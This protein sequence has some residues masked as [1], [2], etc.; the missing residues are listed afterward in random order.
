MPRAAYTHEQVAEV[1]HDGY[2]PEPNSGCWLWFKGWTEQ[3][4]SHRY[5]WLCAKGKVVRAHRYSWEL[6]NG[7]IPKGLLVCH[8]CDTPACVNPKHLFLG[9]H[10]DNMQDCS[11]KGRVRAPIGE[12][13][14]F[15]KLTEEQVRE[16][17]ATPG[18]WRRDGGVSN[19]KMAKKYG[20]GI[21]IIHNIRA[22]EKWKHL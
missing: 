10:K 13:S 17:R 11:K 3:T 16:I 4:P 21:T 7:P 1:F 12:A 20:V 22:G 14:P 5:G 6:H 15:A 2:I 8:K 18:G 9:T 19:K